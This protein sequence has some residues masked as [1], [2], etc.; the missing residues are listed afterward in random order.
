MFRWRQGTWRAVSGA[1]S[2]RALGRTARTPAH[3]APATYMCPPF[4]TASHPARVI[5]QPA[6]RRPPAAA[7]PHRCAGRAARPE[8]AL[9]RQ[10][11]S[12]C[13]QG[14]AAPSC[15]AAADLA[16]LD[17][18]GLLLQPDGQ[19]PDPGTEADH[20]RHLD[21]PGGRAR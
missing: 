4:L 10:P 20:G 12:A 3:P 15:R 14:G 11:C 7:G 2:L 8:T 5:I 9:R 6:G 19:G 18:A 16:G 13:F 21:H 17:L 1:V